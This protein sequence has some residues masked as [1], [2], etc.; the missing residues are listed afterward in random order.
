M[1]YAVVA[2]GGLVILVSFQY[3]LWGRKVY[4]GV[5]HTFVEPVGVVNSGSLESPYNGE[6]L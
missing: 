1:N 2:I 6:K 4:N 3:L 5:V